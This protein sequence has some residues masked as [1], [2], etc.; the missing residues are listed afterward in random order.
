MYTCSIWYLLD[1]TAENVSN[2]C[3]K[4]SQSWNEYLVLGQ[5]KKNEVLQD[6]RVYRGS[7]EVIGESTSASGNF[8]LLSLFYIIPETVSSS[9]N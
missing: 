2:E 1:L 5:K 3:P 4:G 9:A 6:G 7:Y 8:L